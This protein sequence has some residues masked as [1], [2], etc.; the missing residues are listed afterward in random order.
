[1][2]ARADDRIER[3]DGSMRLRQTLGR[4]LTLSPINR[5][6]WENFKSNR[7]GYWSLIVFLGLF[8]F[9]LFAEV[10]ANDERL[11]APEAAERIV[12]DAGTIDALLAGITQTAAAVVKPGTLVNP[13]ANWYFLIA[14]SV[15]I[16]VVGTWVTEKIV[17][18]RLGAY[19]GDAKPDEI[20]PL[21]TDEKRGLLW[22]VLATLG[23]TGLI[24]WGT[25][26]EGGF[27][28]DPK[29]PTFL[30][31]YF[32]RGLIF[33]IFLYGF[34][35]G[36][37]YGL[38]ARTIKNDNDVVRGMDASISTMGSYIVMAFFASQF[39]AYFNW[40]NLGTIMAV[41]GAGLI[42]DIG[43]QGSPILLMVSLVLFTATVNLIIGSA[44]AKWTRLSAGTRATGCAWPWWT[45]HAIR[46]R[47]RPPPSSC[48][49]RD[50]GSRCSRSSRG[51]RARGGRTRR[52]SRGPRPNRRAPRARSTPAPAR[53]PCA[54]A[55]PPRRRS[56]PRRR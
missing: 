18:P 45:L 24:M 32:I 31:S 19:T 13:A 33:F 28:L 41:K 10:V 9:S 25:L 22:A 3:R 34:V 20:K 53:A 16:T 12:R 21:G 51:S 11:D 6:R 38:G 5:R 48:W 17:E 46:A 36:L 15:L 54:G 30:G 35:S 55:R 44:S 29:N 42:K 26:T 49:P 7:R 43:L 1:M 14:A 40:T 56:S 39:L 8:V 2:D 52:S 27:L 47:R 37:A 50:G 23:L 4:A